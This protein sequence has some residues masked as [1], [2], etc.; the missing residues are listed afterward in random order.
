M[1]HFIQILWF[2]GRRDK[3]LV[4]EWEFWMITLSICP[5][6]NFVTAV[7]LYH[8]TREVSLSLSFLKD[9]RN[10]ESFLVLVLL[11]KEHKNQQ[12]SKQNAILNNRR[13]MISICFYQFKKCLCNSFLVPSA[14]I[15]YM[16]TNGFLISSSAMLEF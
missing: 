11:H 6:V 16:A 5:K 9:R 15:L 2:L 12:G 8:W 1:R 4:A 13:R 7:T 14:L 3:Y 10:L